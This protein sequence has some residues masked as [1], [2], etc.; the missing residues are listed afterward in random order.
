MKFKPTYLYIKTH[1]TTGLKYFGKTTK[2]DP[3]KYHGSGEYWQKHIQKH[4]KD[5]L[6]EI[7][8]YYED[9][10]ECVNAAIEFSIKNNIVES[11]DWANFKIE[12]GLDGGSDKGHTK[13]ITE[14]WLKAAKEKSDKSIEDGTHP[15]M[16][17]QGSK[18]AKERNARLLAEGNHNFQGERG[19][20]HSKNMNKRM[21]ESGT[22]P[23]QGDAG[24]AL[25]RKRIE[26]GT[27]SGLK[28]GQVSVVDKQGNAVKISKE[29]FWSQSG[30]KEDWEYVGIT[31]KIAK[32]RLT[33]SKK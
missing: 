16:G 26:D 4:G 30:P 19:S 21:L 9:K 8:G 27:F 32:N 2:L 28:P 1:R 33:Q 15:W 7:V 12:N 25:T 17:E 3:S 20:A 10:D 24:R 23:F 13:T 5:I 18:M 14:R 11:K 6:T 22:H 31:S 29:L